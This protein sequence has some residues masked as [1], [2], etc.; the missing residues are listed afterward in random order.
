[1]TDRWSKF[2]GGV[3]PVTWASNLQMTFV[4]RRSRCTMTAEHRCCPVTRCVHQTWGS[5]SPS[6]PPGPIDWPH[7]CPAVCLGSVW[8]VFISVSL[9]CWGP[10][11]AAFLCGLF[12]SL[13]H[14]PSVFAVIWSS[15]QVSFPQS[16]RAVCPGVLFSI[17]LLL[18]LC[19]V[20]LL[21]LSLSLSFPLSKL[22]LSPTDLVDPKHG[23]KLGLSIASKTN[24][25]PSLFFFYLHS[26]HSSS[27]CISNY[28]QSVSIPL[29]VVFVLVHLVFWCGLV[30][31]KKTNIGGVRLK[32]AELFKGFV[33]LNG[34]LSHSGLLPFVKSLCLQHCVIK[35]NQEC[36]LP[37][38]TC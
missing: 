33:P 12:S 34:F 6:S 37:S 30:S 2:L 25:P 18:F 32:F 4:S 17:Y 20:L 1:M 21:P 24:V 11:T 7:H 16:K 3:L 27:P 15:Q 28:T 36:N 26:I 9:P 19:L 23:M 38:T 13:S 8:T 29:G 5:C 10:E 14:S 31:R 35:L 22:S